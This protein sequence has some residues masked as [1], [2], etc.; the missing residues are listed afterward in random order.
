MP[1]TSGACQAAAGAAHCIYM[2]HSKRPG[3]STD[4]P[5]GRAKALHGVLIW[6][7]EALC[8]FFLAPPASCLPLLETKR[9][10][11]PPDVSMSELAIG[12]NEPQRRCFGVS[13]QPTVA[14]VMDEGVKQALLGDRSLLHK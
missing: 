2:R 14:D 9:K 13:P 5:A 6:L 8:C 1:L 3:C 4:D 12:M 7:I 10:M 11:T